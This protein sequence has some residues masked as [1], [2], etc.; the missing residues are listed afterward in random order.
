MRNLRLRNAQLL[1]LAQLALA[2][3]Q[4]AL[5]LAYPLALALAQLALAQLALALA[6][7]L[8][9]AS[10][11]LVVVAC[12][13]QCTKCNVDVMMSWAMGNRQ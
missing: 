6:C 8:P 5:A 7:R 11:S 2:L 12:C 4:L 9:L 3:A 1:A 10:C 13:W